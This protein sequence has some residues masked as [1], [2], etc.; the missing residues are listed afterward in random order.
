MKGKPL[1]IYISKDKWNNAKYSIRD[2]II[3]KLYAAK[4]TL[5]IDKEIAVGIYI[6]A[7]EEFG[8]LLL[9][10]NCKKTVDGRYIINYR[11]EFV[12]YQ[13][14]FG[15]AFDY[16]Q[17]NNSYECIVLNNL[18]SYT[19]DSYSRK[20]FL[21]EAE[22]ILGIFNTNFSVTKNNNDKYDIMKI[23]NVN[24]NKLNDAIN[25][26]TKVIDTFEV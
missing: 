8:K 14:K 10:K 11:N 9:L 24:E 12:N 15:K 4:Q 18:N 5:T 21:V 22:E 19:W 1:R 6:Y 13:V 16:L 2:G 23:P 25:E 26:L 17:N 3:K 7:L 20:R